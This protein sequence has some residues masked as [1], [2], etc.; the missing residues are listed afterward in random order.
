MR[1][2]AEERLRT[3]PWE[4]LRGLGPALD[5]PLAEVL[6]GAV[7]DAALSRVLRARPGLD[8]RRRAAVAEAILGVALWR[9]R[10]RAA[11]GGTD[12]SP[13]LLLAALLR[14]LGGR[15]DAAELS[16]LPQGALPPPLPPPVGLADRFSLPDWLAEEIRRAA[17][18]EAEALA[19]AL[20]LP[21]PV[22]LR[23]NGLRT[24]RDALAARLRGEGVETRP[25]L[26]A[27]ACLV[28]TS[29]RPNVLG[30]ASH[31]EGLFEVQDEGS[32]LL[33]AIVGARPGETVLDACAG[34][35]G[36]TL[37]LAAD[38]GRNGRVHAADPDAEKLRR[39]AARAV[40]AGAAAAIALHSAPPEGLVVDRVLVDA[41]CSEL[42]ALRRGPDVRWRLDPGAFA[43]LP[44]LQLGILT[45][46]A[47]HARPGGT[48][49]YATCTFRRE[50]N[51][52]V[53]LAFERTH[54]GFSRVAPAVNP[55][56]LTPDGFL[57]TWPHAHGTDAFF[58]AAWVRGLEPHDSAAQLD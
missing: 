51:E 42:G 34:A 2:S 56:A 49:V 31:R 32:Q 47:G 21:G 26:L 40:R 23:A 8:A 50:E 30:L 15:A 44:A 5:A 27:P 33:G 24:S 37:L 46:A 43:A 17:G 29:A 38:V 54:P 53:A 20:D 19:D 4:A 7:A 22:C 14:D 41:P 6:A 57:R 16:E 1:S 25:G 48:L 28:V 9:R 55:S 35:G 18:G 58:A 52:D 36:K 39:L 11:L 10:L 45:Q 3:I 12:A 13:R